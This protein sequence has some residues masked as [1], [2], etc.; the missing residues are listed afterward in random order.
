MKIMNDPMLIYSLV[1]SPLT[2]SGTGGPKKLALTVE[3]GKSSAE[4]Q[5]AC[6]AIMIAVP[7][8]TSEHD[9]TDHPETIKMNQAGGLEPRH[10]GGWLPQ[11]QMNDAST[12]MIYTWTPQFQTGLL[13]ATWNLRLEL[14]HI[15]VNVTS[16]AV[17]IFIAE[18][19]TAKSSGDEATY[20]VT[21]G[22]LQTATF[23][24]SD[25][26]SVFQPLP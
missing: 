2:G 19:T 25:M 7:I 1:A 13:D 10:G 16:A 15:Q 18:A 12:Y 17:E 6:E 4:Q 8:G 9:L 23:H 22:D 3:P 24:P 14:N 11:A 21:R 20:K 26:L 5:I